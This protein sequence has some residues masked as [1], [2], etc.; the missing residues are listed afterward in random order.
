MK[1]LLDEL[2]SY[3]NNYG[4]QL[5]PGAVMKN[6]SFMGN[7]AEIQTAMGKDVD[8]LMRSM[9]KKV[10]GIECKLGNQL[11][12]LTHFITSMAVSLA[13]DLVQ[14]LTWMLTEPHLTILPAMMEHLPGANMGCTAAM[15]TT[16]PLLPPHAL[17]VGSDDGNLGS[18]NRLVPLPIMGI[19]IPDIKSWPGAWREVV[20]QWEEN[21]P[22]RGFRALW[23]WPHEWYT[24]VMRPVTAS[25]RRERELIALAYER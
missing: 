24:G 15:G 13:G 10:D 6:V 3:E 19:M 17:L 18:D 11:G 9:H 4:D 8:N 5:A 20:R 16:P 23:D 7:H 25:K 14:L 22:S 2:E 12:E 1:Y 21:E